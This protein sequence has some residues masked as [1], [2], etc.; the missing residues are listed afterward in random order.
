MG[1]PKAYSG[2][3]DPADRQK[4]AGQQG[5]EAIPCE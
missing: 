2:Q 5:R 4:N 3:V 1:C